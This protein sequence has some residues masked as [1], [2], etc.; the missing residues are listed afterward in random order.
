MLLDGARQVGKSMLLAQIFARQFPQ[1]HRF[2]LLAEPTLRQAFADS[3]RPEDVLRDLQLLK[4]RTIDADRDLIIFDEVGECEPA[5]DA[6]KYFAEQMPHG[7][8]CATGSNIGLIKRFPVGKVKMR[9]VFPLSFAEFL[10]ASGE[11]QALEAYGEARQSKAAHTRLWSLLLDYYFVGG[12]PEAVSTWFELRKAPIHERTEAVRGIQRGLLQGYELD[13]AKY[14]G[15]MSV[16]ETTRLFRNVATQLQSNRDGSVKRYRFNQSGGHKKSYS[17]LH[18]HFELLEQTRLVAR[19]P[20]IDGRPQS[21]LKVQA[22]DSRFKL[23]LFDVGLLGCALNISYREQRQQSLSF[24]GFIA[25]NFVCN[26][27]RAAGIYPLYSWA[28]RAAE[29][30]FLH[31]D[32]RGE[33]MP[34]EVKSGQRTRAKSLAAYRKMYSPKR[35]LKLV[36][37]PGNVGSDAQNMVWPLYYAAHVAGL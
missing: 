11:E 37:S 28:Q 13:L 10:A 20:I 18:S 31:K 35:T 32:A 36:G 12:M 29:I 9:Q 15:R 8:V 4:N 6:L 16:A 14:A 17:Q 1:V 2:D 27:L 25:E 24:K 22:K 30:E 23:F 21:P 3:L 26:E 34:I 33:I 5:L 19:C 7:F